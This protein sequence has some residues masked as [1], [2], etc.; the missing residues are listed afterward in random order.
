MR[1]ILTVLAVALLAACGSDGPTGPTTDDVAGR[2]LLLSIG[3]QVLPLTVEETETSTFELLDGSLLLRRDGTCQESTNWRE[4]VD[5][6][7]VV[8]GGVFACTFVLDGPV[9]R[10]AFEDGST[11]QATWADDQLTYSLSGQPVIYER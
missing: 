5:G 10:I 2:Y 3:G 6:E 7:S 11:L 4:T 8:Y 1:R 9:V